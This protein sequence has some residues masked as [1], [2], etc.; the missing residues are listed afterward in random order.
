M[1]PMHVLAADCRAPSPGRR[2]GT[3]AC[4]PPYSL[5]RGRD[6]GHIRPGAWGVA[7]AEPANP[8]DAAAVVSFEI[9]G[10]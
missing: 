6:D 2:I 4:W 1:N 5:E 10:R 8:D 3:S 9:V 7:T